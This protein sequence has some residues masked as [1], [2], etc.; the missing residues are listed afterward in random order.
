MDLSKIT[1][2]GKALFLAYDQGMEH[3]PTDFN[4][5]NIDPERVLAIADSG[6]FTGVILQKG[7]AEKYYFGKSYK[8]PL[9]VKLNGKTNLVRDEDP[10][11]S[12]I[13]SIKEALSYGAKAVGYTIYVGSEFETKMTEEF[14][15]IEQE[16]EEAGIPVIAWMYPRGRNVPD[17]NDPKLIAYAARIGLELGADIVK[18]RY[19][20]DSASFKWVV[21]SAGKTKVVVMGGSKESEE[22]FLER[23]RT[24]MEAGAIG[25]AVGRNVWQA[26]KPLAVAEKIAQIIWAR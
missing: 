14:G 9:I 10:Y 24:V 5:E 3:G 26:E 19:T 25:L 16:A 11:S 1:K 4:E 8:V 17:E 2:Q 12:Q 23:T 7:V 18:I 20:G 13:C 6:Y 21:Q 22:T 15:K